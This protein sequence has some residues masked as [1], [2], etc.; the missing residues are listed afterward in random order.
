M[1]QVEEKHGL[2]KQR[3]PFDEEWMN[4][5][6]TVDQVWSRKQFDEWVNH[7][8][9]VSDSVVKIVGFDAEWKPDRFGKKPSPVA[10]VQLA[11]CTSRWV[12]VS[13]L[14]TGTMTYE[15]QPVFRVMLVSTLDDNLLGHVQQFI[16]KH[17]LNK[18]IQFV[19][20]GLQSDQKKLGKETVQCIEDL[21]KT[22]VS[23]GCPRSGGHPHGLVSLMTEV[24]KIAVP[25]KE[26]TIT[27]SDWSNS[28][29][30]TAQINYAAL[31]AI[32]TLMIHAKLYTM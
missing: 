17:H 13:S 12:W 8:I 23:K 14:S 5:T 1:T 31:D 20:V 25:K 19:G 11:V 32:W 9:P 26:K 2:P 6:V 22:A 7:Y 24:V 10:L 21:A 30:S 3:N 4:Q 27:C 16:I 15:E 18:S 29:L 28:K